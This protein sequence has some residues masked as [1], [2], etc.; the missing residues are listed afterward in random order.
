MSTTHWPEFNNL[1][2]H[3]P[4]NYGARQKL[5]D[6]TADEYTGASSLLWA[7][8]VVNPGFL[9]PLI[10]YKWTSAVD[11][12]LSHLCN[13]AELVEYL[14][15]PNVGWTHRRFNG[16]KA[17]HHALELPHPG[18]IFWKL[19]PREKQFILQGCAR[20]D[21]IDLWDPEAKILSAE[22][23]RTMQWAPPE[24]IIDYACFY[25][26][27]RRRTVKVKKQVRRI[28]EHPVLELE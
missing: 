1:A 25:R 27:P 26:L 9:T 6:G 5:I 19:L 3:Y 4:L 10:S 20:S 7:L 21:H 13:A 16:P 15:G 23:G 17:K 11:K 8:D 2:N 28:T 18:I 14:G 24:N 22:G 12:P